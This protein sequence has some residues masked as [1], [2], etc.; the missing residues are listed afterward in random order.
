MRTVLEERFNPEKLTPVIDHYYHLAVNDVITDPLK[1][2]NMTSYTNE[3][4]RG[5]RYLPASFFRIA[6]ELTLGN[7]Q[8][9]NVLTRKEQ[10]IIRRVALGQS[11]RQIAN[12]MQLSQRS[13]ETYRYRIMRKLRVTNSAALVDYAFRNRLLHLHMSGLD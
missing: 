9:P 3:I 1:N 11:S 8:A 7:Q 4:A 6:N 12:D 10:D 5:K 2:F 13:V